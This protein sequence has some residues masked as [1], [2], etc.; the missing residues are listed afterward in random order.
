M[1]RMKPDKNQ[2]A[3]L[4]QARIA[5]GYKTQRSFS[6]ALGIKQPTYHQHEAA[7]RRLDDETA[8]IYAEK[9]DVDVGWI[10]FGEGRGPDSVKEPELAEISSPFVPVRLLGVVQAGV[11]SEGPDIPDDDVE[12]FVVPENPGYPK[13]FGLE[14]RGDS[15]NL[16]FPEGT[17]LVCVS[18]WDYFEEVEEGEG[19]ERCG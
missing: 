13:I 2:A 3:R 19:I 7:K 5:R 17:L 4:R 16:I 1:A 6:D 11:W 14:V 8:L 18:R 15:T 12:T 9:L 10:K